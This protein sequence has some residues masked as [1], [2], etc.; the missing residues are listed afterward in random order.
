M[1]ACAGAHHWA[2]EL[3]ALG[4]E[5]RL[6]P[7][8]YVKPFVKRQKNDMADAEAIC[9]A[10]QRPTMRFVQWRRAII[11]LLCGM[12]APLLLQFVGEIAPL[13][14]DL[15][16]FVA[17][18]FRGVCAPGLGHLGAVSTIFD[19]LH[20][21]PCAGGLRQRFRGVVQGRICP[22]LRYAT[23]LGHGHPTVAL[24]TQSIGPIPRMGQ[25]DGPDSAQRVPIRAISP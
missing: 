24:D 21:T 7:P 15:R 12:V 3:T 17:K 4:H 19:A 13:L 1:E 5:P 16:H 20:E 9:E 11:E 14:G 10:A 2:R 23:Q 25:V 22:P 8:P 6:I 18:G